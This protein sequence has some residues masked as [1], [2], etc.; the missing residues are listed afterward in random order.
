MPAQLDPNKEATRQF[1][2]LP[3]SSISGQGLRFPVRLESGMAGY[4]EDIHM[5]FYPRFGGSLEMAVPNVLNTKDTIIYQASLKRMRD[6]E[7]PL[8]TVD[9]VAMA[10]FL[11]P[12]D[13]GIKAYHAT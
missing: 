1:R 6:R 13:P 10:L 8:Q 4:A 11:A 9:F 2:A 12:S 5:S 3:Q 7:D